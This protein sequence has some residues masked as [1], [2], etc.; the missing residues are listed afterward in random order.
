MLRVRDR[1]DRN[2]PVKERRWLMDVFPVGHKAKADE[3]VLAYMLDPD[4]EI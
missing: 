3:D 1:H 4:K 2:A